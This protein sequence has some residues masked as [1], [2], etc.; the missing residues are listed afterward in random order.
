M[1][2]GCTE[3]AESTLGPRVWEDWRHRAS[4][5]RNSA[6]CRGTPLRRV[7]E[8]PAGGLHRDFGGVRLLETAEDTI[9]VIDGQGLVVDVN[10][11][12]V[13]EFG[14]SR[15]EFRGRL[16]TDFYH[17]D[18]RDMVASV[19]RRLMDEKTPLRLTAPVVRRGGSA[20]GVPAARGA[21]PAAAVTSGPMDMGLGPAY[22]ERVDYQCVTP[23]GTVAFPLPAPRLPAVPVAGPVAPSVAL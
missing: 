4:L 21:V 10:P 6:L 1:R 11:R 20:A 15:E 9:V 3:T 22:G 5:D 23:G 7:H 8:P 12:A 16:L 18:H 17:P 19:H 13:T 14:F 2:G